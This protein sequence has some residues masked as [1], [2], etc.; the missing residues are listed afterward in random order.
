MKKAILL[1][2]AAVVT[3]YAQAQ[4]V[5]YENDLITPKDLHNIG[6][7]EVG[8]DSLSTGNIVWI[9]TELLP[10]MHTKHS[11]YAYIID[12]EADMQLGDKFFKVKNGD[13]VFIPKGTVHAVKVTS[14]RPLKVFAVQAPYS[15]G[16][17]RLY[18]TK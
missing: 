18:T 11:E 2:A 6:T 13:I 14:K 16:T 5:V 1:F 10:H 12:G 3:N 15:D 17:D 7:K 9:T 8:S 4:V